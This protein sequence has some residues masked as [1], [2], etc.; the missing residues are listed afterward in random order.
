MKFV[1]IASLRMPRPL[2]SLQNSEFWDMELIDS[3]SSMLCGYNCEDS[4]S[5][6]SGT[7]DS[8]CDFCSSICCE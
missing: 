3:F 5:L 2:L 6:R 1:I 4:E 7:M 8:R